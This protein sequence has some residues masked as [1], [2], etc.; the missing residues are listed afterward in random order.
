MSRA[1][2]S[3][4]TIVAALVVAGCSVETTNADDRQRVEVLEADPLLN[5]D[6]QDVQLSEVMATVGDADQPLG[7]TTPNRVR[8]AGRVVGDP[9]E[10]MRQVLAET[11]AGGWTV[12]SVRCEEGG[13]NFTILGRRYFDGFLA[14]VEATTFPSGEDQPFAIEVTAPIVGREVDEEPP[15]LDSPGAT[16]TCLA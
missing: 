9:A 12:V 11:V 14:T 16:E 5:F 10:V 1:R 13:R 4:T 7:G 2:T 8:R 6:F 3:L 15:T